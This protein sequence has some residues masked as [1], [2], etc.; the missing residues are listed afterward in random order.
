MTRDNKLS[1]KGFIINIDSNFS[2]LILKHS[3]VREVYVNDP[4]DEL[5]VLAHGSLI[6][7]TN[8]NYIYDLR[9]HNKRPF[10][11]H[12]HPVLIK[13]NL[14]GV[15]EK[16][17]QQDLCLTQFSQLNQKLIKQTQI[18]KL[19]GKK[20]KVL[21]EFKVSNDFDLYDIIYL[22]LSPDIF[23]ENHDIVQKFFNELIPYT[24]K[25]WIHENNLLLANIK[26][27]FYHQSYLNQAYIVSL[28]LNNEDALCLTDDKDVFLDESQFSN[29]NKYFVE[30]IVQFYQVSMLNG[31][32]IQFIQEIL[33]NGV[34]SSNIQIV[35]HFV[36]FEDLKS[37]RK[38]L[39]KR[40][41]LISDD[42]IID[43][44]TIFSIPTSITNKQLGQLIDIFNQLSKEN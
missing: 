44:T 27:F 36:I 40:G 29:S 12:N 4:I 34:L 33:D 37:N 11:G 24:D 23:N 5:G 19:T 42:N 16:Q 2:D 20:I 22:E 35:G 18:G 26:S 21:T 30:K 15:Q 13:A 9:L 1:D 10:C 25:L 3:V 6:E 8:H 38:S 7:T 14:L 31:C 28:S 43:D 39:L 41:I 17:D 32:R